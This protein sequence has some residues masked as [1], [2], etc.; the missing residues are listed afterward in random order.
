[1]GYLFTRQQLYERVWAKPITVVAK[2]LQ[3]SDVGLAKACRRGAVPLPPRGYWAKRQAGQRLSPAP[4]PPRAPGASD[5][6][7][8]GTGQRQSI[9]NVEPDGKDRN[10]VD[11]LT[12]APPEPPVYDETL[13]QVKARIEAAYPKRFRFDH[14]WDHPHPMIGRLL[15]E[16]EARRVQQAKSGHSWDGPRFASRFEQRRLR[17]LSNLL[18][19][20]FQFDVQP[21][22]RGRE[23]REIHLCVGNSQLE[24][25][26]D[27]AVK[28]RPRGRTAAKDPDREPMAID[29]KIARWKH[30]EAEERLFWC[31]SDAGKLESQLREIAIEI[32]WAGE[33]QLRK[34]RQFFY[35]TDCWFYQQD[36]DKEK[37]RRAEAERLERERIAQA[38]ADRVNRL[39][40]QVAARQRAQQIRTYVEEVIMSPHAVEGRAFDGDRDV[41]ARWALT[42]A[43]RLDPLA[44]AGTEDAGAG[45]PLPAGFAGRPDL[46]TP[47]IPDHQPQVS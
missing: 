12:Q 3:V 28:L 43:A 2:T 6:I 18:R 42:V 15:Q 16:D 35:D 21:S 47:D 23:A 38:E 33:R 22:V 39:F 45:P 19:L 11:I 41:W 26:V 30:G 14:T 10:T 34:G 31:D 44:L 8:V 29:L 17:F 9:S 36:I 32:V 1:M 27:A 20:L 40:A 25:A 4:L 37:Q 13:D 7:E 46:R 24:V 5:V